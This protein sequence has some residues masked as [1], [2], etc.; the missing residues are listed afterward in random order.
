MKIIKIKFCNL[1][2]FDAVKGVGCDF[3]NENTPCV[4]ILGIVSRE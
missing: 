1:R 3:L 2:D 4:F